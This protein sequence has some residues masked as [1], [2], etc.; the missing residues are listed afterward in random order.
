MPMWMHSSFYKKIL[1]KKANNFVRFFYSKRNRE[2]FY[3][4]IKFQFLTPYYDFVIKL[5]VPEQKIKHEVIKSIKLNKSS[6]ILDFGSGTGTLAIMISNATESQI[7]DTYDPDPKMNEIAKEKYAKEGKNINQVF[8]D[9]INTDI[10]DVVFST[11]VFH[12]LTLMQKRKAFELIFNILKP[13]GVFVLGDWAKPEGVFSRFKYF[14]LQVIDNFETTQ[15]N[16]DGSLEKLIQKAGF[17]NIEILK[18]YNTAL[19]TFYIWEIRK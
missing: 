3:P 13:N 12:H 15:S 19:G 11:W 6:K 9:S 5:L 17:K 2:V 4:A 14:L 16:I 7:I 18:T 10:Y 8:I 1:L